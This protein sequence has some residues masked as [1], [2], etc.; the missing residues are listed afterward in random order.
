MSRPAHTLAAACALVL[1]LAAPGHAASTK[2]KAHAV[3]GILQKVDGQT[4]IVQTSK[5]PESVVLTSDS[6]IHRGPATIDRSTL[7]TYTGQ[8]VKVRYVDLNGQRQAQTV[9]LATTG[10]HPT[11]LPASSAAQ[12]GTNK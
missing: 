9:T 1:S 3:V 6:R 7:P 4:L 12:R 2:T 5:G 11:D 8:R 10:S